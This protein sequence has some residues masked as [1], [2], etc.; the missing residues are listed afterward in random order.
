MH[1]EQK[2]ENVLN[3][4]FRKSSWSWNRIS[5]ENNICICYLLKEHQHNKRLLSHLVDFGDVC[6][7]GV[8]RG[9]KKSICADEADVEQQEVVVISH[10]ILQEVPWKLKIKCKAGADFL[11]NFGCFHLAWYC[12]LRTEG[13]EVI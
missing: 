1:E 4:F 10:N 7:G 2:G 5:I 13:G 3:V 8:G 9:W 6:G 12:P 11:L